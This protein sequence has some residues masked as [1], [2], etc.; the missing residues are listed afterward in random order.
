MGERRSGSW[1]SIF[2]LDSYPRAGVRAARQSSEKRTQRKETRAGR[3]A[4][5]RAR[6]ARRRSAAIERIERRGGQ[7]TPHGPFVMEKEPIRANQGGLVR[8]KTIHDMENGG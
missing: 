8:H 5:R 2:D 4:E 3:R 7:A 6:R 1:K